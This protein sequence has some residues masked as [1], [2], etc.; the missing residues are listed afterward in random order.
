MVCKVNGSPRP[1]AWKGR[2]VNVG[3]TKVGKTIDLGFPITTRTAKETLGAVPYTLEIKGNTMVSID[4]PGMNGALYAH[5]QYGSNQ[6]PWRKVQ[7]FVPDEQLS[8]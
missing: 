8:W 3:A 7:R 5:K 2:Y 1:L 4:P 6:V